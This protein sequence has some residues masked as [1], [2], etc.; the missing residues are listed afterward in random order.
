MWWLEPTL[1]IVP[2]D[3]RIKVLEFLPRHQASYRQVLLPIN[4]I[5]SARAFLLEKVHPQEVAQMFLVFP[6]LEVAA[7]LS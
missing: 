7:A 4:R 6:L 3:T 5:V 2:A 1:A